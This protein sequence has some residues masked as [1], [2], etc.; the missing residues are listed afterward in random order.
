MAKKI[1]DV[2]N[3]LAE[4]GTGQAFAA[5]FAKDYFAQA[6]GSLP[7]TEIDL[8]IFRL[9]METK[10]LAPEQSIYEM[11]R[12]LNVT[13]AKARSLL[14][15]HQLRTMSDTDVDN[16]VLIEVTTAKF[17]L[18][19]QRLGFGVESP[20]VRA[21]IQAKAK[22]KRVFADISLSGEI[23]YV[24]MNQIGDFISAFLPDA[25]VQRL[26]ERLRR[27]GVVDPDS[28][29]KALNKIGETMAAEAA[30]AGGKAAAK[31]L[32]EQLMDWVKRT[33]EGADVDLPELLDKA[34]ETA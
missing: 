33:L 14:F 28:L 5:G 17:G 34:L 13:P 23:L 16:S 29:T 10:V 32:G 11:A 25:K 15:Q 27:N 6:F 22:D 8:L 18:D 24:P 20:L 2:R 4:A 30:K 26:I 21:A 1:E 19:G 7:K 31:H 3:A 9:L 12:C